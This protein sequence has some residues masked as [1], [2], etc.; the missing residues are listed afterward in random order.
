[1][2]FDAEILSRLRMTQLQISSSKCQNRWRLTSGFLL[3]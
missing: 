1:M 2:G 3:S